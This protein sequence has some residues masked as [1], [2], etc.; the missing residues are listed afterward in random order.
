IAYLAAFEA[1]IRVVRPPAGSHHADVGRAVAFVI[2]VFRLFGSIEADGRILEMKVVS[3]LPF[4]AELVSAKPANKFEG[5]N[6]GISFL[7]LRYTVPS[8][9]DYKFTVTLKPMEK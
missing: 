5:Q 6:E 3:R 2:Q 7:R 8:W 9:T 4:I 1:E